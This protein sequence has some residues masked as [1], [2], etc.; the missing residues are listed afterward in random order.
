MQR[1]GENE[2]FPTHTHTCTPVQ[3]ARELETLVSD[4][5]VPISKFKTMNDQ[6]RAAVKDLQG[7]NMVK[8]LKLVRCANR[9][10]KGA[11]V[12]HSAPPRA[13]AQVRVFIGARDKLRAV[14]PPFAAPALD[15]SEAE[16]DTTP[17][18]DDA[19]R[20]VRRLEATADLLRYR[21]EMPAFLEALSG[22]NL[23][24]A[25]DVASLASRTL[26]FLTT[27]YA[28]GEVEGELQ[29]LARALSGMTADELLFVA[30]LHS[31]GGL[32]EFLATFES[33]AVFDTQASVVRGGP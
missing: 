33:M 27:D 31:H 16:A 3:V 8:E 25:A 23:L 7:R 28:L 32:L 6:L 1:G 20:S 18:T 14:R 2:G 19:V 17:V 13:R 10:G 29:L 11:R 4:R 9:G 12:M 15:H 22:L 24:P 21:A 30:R 26:R 5:T